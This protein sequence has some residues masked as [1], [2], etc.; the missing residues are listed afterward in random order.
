MIDIVG[1][2]NGELQVLETDTQRAKNILSV[3][4][5][6]LEYAPELGIDLKYFLSEKFS[7][8]NESFSAYLVQRLADFG[9]NVTSVT[10]EIQ[11]LCTRLGFKI[12]DS[13]SGSDSLIAR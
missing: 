13:S 4:L 12:Y 3:Q 10:S 1:V 8:Q 11:A 5:G 2:T 6:T 7:F 9:L